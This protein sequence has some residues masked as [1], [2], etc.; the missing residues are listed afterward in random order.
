MDPDATYELWFENQS[1]N[2]GLA[3]VFHGKGNVTANV[4]LN[5]LAWMIQGAN[6][7]AAIQFRWVLDYAFLWRDQDPPQSQ[8]IVPADPETANSTVLSRN[9]FGYKFSSPSAGASGQLSIEE[10]DSVPSENQAL[11]GIGMHGAGTFALNASPNQTCVFTPTQTLDYHITF[12]QY[13]LQVGDVLVPA[14]L[15]PAGVVRF[16]AGVTTMT[17][18]LDSSNAWSFTPGGPSNGSTEKASIYEAGKG[19]VHYDRR[20][21]TRRHQPRWCLKRDS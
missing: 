9:A 10:D 2:P 11:V 16:P 18:I 21:T 7:G 4:Q 5:Q 1:P 8:G 12:G 13:T 17:A 6:P 15:N 14:A 20:I 3:C 19:V